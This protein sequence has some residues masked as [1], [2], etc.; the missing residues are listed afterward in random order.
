MR[1]IVEAEILSDECKKIKITL[2]SGEVIIGRSTG[3]HP[4]FDDEGIHPA[5]DDEGKELDY[6]VLHIDAESPAA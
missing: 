5:F 3:I 6:D 1:K 4:A 2:T